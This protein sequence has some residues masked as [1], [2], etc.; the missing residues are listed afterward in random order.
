MHILNCSLLSTHIAQ[1]KNRNPC[2]TCQAFVANTLL[3]YAHRGRERGKRL[4]YFLPSNCSPL[5][6]SL[7]ILSCGSKQLLF[8]MLQPVKVNE[9][10]AMGQHKSHY[11]ETMRRIHGD[12]RAYKNTQLLS[13]SELDH[14]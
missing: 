8:E 2:L 11:I 13:K 6:Q 1:Y 9:K 3:R 4:S 14:Y 5:W 12:L 7:Q 10:A